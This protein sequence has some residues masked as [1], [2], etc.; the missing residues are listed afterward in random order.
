MAIPYAFVKIMKGE[1]PY[2]DKSNRLPKE[3]AKFLMAKGNMRGRYLGASLDSCRWGSQTTIM[4]EMSVKGL[5]GF[6][7]NWMQQNLKNFT[8][9][10]HKK[11]IE[12][13][14]T[15]FELPFINYETCPRDKNHSGIVRD[16]GGRLRCAHKSEKRFKPS[17]VDYWE[18]FDELSGM[19]QRHYFEDEPSDHLPGY[20][21]DAER[22]KR[23]LEEFKQ[24]ESS[25]LVTDIC[26]AILS[27]KGRILPLETI[28]KRLDL[29]PE[30]EIV[31][32]KVEFPFDGWDLAFYVQKW[33]QQLFDGKSPIFEK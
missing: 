17:F 16:L 31:Y 23:E 26:Y 25:L 24:E 32:D 10:W 30:T 20:K 27:D 4:Y 1:E 19:I 28:I 12:E 21:K 7:Q 14:Y 15:K 22:Y 5:M 6:I 33:Y 18:S 11:Q 9:L 13:L 2:L 3:Q 8:G 29:R